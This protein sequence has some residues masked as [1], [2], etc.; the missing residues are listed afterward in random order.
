MFD[1]ARDANDPDT[2]RRVARILPKAAGSAAD[3]RAAAQVLERFLRDPLRSVQASALEGLAELA[4]RE[5]GGRSRALA[6]LQAALGSPVPAVAARA[7][8]VIARIEGAV[9]GRRESRRP[10][11]P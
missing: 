2:K 10:F 5:R 3:R 11:H 4:L 8:I 1:I 9:R 6:L 7:R